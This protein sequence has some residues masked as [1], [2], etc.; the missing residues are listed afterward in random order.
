[1][2]PFK[3]K[4][5]EETVEYEDAGFVNIEIHLVGGDSI[6]AYNCTDTDVDNIIFWMSEGE[7]KDM[8]SVGNLYMFA[9]DIRFFTYKSNG[10]VKV[11][12]KKDDD[13]QS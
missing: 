5:I 10:V 11:K 4:E 8:L 1:M 3:K 2:W 7:G 6:S 13:I 9:K 12:E